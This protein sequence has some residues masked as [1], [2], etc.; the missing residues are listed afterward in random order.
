MLEGG[1]DGLFDLLEESQDDNEMVLAIVMTINNLSQNDVLV[2]GLKSRGV[3]DLLTETFKNSKDSNVKNECAEALK[4]IVP[5]RVQHLQGWSKGRRAQRS[6]T[7]SLRDGI[8]DNVRKII[9]V[10]ISDL[11]NQDRLRNSGV[12]PHLLTLLVDENRDAELKG[13][14]LDAITMMCINNSSSQAAVT[15]GDDPTGLDL[16]IKLIID[17]EVSPFVQTRA[18][19]TLGALCWNNK[20]VQNLILEKDNIV[21]FLVSLID[22]YDDALKRIALTT[23][24]AAVDD[25]APSQ[26]VVQKCGG[27]HKLV[28]NLKREQEPDLMV[29]AASAALCALVKGNVPAQETCAKAVPS[30]VFLLE[31]SVKQKAGSFVQEHLASALLELSRNNKSASAMLHRLHAVH[32][33]VTVLQAPESSGTLLYSAV[34]IVWELSKNDKKRIDLVQNKDLAASLQELSSSPDPLTRDAANKLLQRLA[35]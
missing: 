9:Q 26:R 35:P 19:R 22:T 29:A 4:S 18:V 14:A 2:S 23:V 12:I 3:V 20:M 10:L 13:L 28:N 11:N 16:V 34:A 21:P 15:D 8:K 30:L 31:R 1:A 17:P 5:D 6:E 7:L 32:T 27:D 24:A 25:N 33:L